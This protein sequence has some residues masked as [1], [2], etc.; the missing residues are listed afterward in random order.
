MLPVDVNC[1]E[2]TMWFT[3]A[4]SGHR[5]AMVFNMNKA[6]VGAPTIADLENLNDTFNSWMDPGTFV[7]D[8]PLSALVS[9][10]FILTETISRRVLT[11]GPVWVT[12]TNLPGGDSSDQLPDYTSLV[13]T[14]HT[15]DGGR[16]FTG[17]KYPVGATENRNT[18]GRP[19]AGYRDALLT[20]FG[21]LRTALEGVAENWETIVVSRVT[22][23]V[24]RV[25]PQFAVVE[26]ES[27]DLQWDTQR[28][29]GRS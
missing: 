1:I 21:Q 26:A 4:L 24:E 22:G 29:R 17:R 2:V 12:P 8:E 13:I 7:G 3:H 5:S 10:N 19:S 25:T 23:G 14:Q 28:R 9:D 18:D 16:S 27:A 20:S 11:G 6:S 15:L